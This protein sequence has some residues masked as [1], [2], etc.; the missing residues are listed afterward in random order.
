[1][2]DG[3]LD[4]TGNETIPA[5]SAD[6][7]RTFDQ[8]KQP[9]MPEPLPPLRSRL[10]EEPPWDPQSPIAMVVAGVRFIVYGSLG[11]FLLLIGLE[12]LECALLI[13]THS[14]HCFPGDSGISAEHDVI[15]KGLPH[16]LGGS[17]L[18]V[19]GA[20]L[21]LT[22]IRRR[23]QHWAYLWIGLF[24]ILSGGVVGI[25]TYPVLPITVLCASFMVLMGASSVLFGLGLTR[26]VWGR[27]RT[28]VWQRMGGVVSV[29]VT[30][31]ALYSFAW[32][33]RQ[34]QIYAR[35]LA[36]P[37]G[38][39]SSCLRRTSSAYDVRDALGSYLYDTT[40]NSFTA[41]KVDI[42]T[43]R[44]ILIH[45]YHMEYLRGPDPEFSLVHYRPIDS[46]G[47]GS[48]EDF[49]LRLRYVADAPQGGY[50]DVTSAYTR[51]STVC[52][53]YGISPLSDRIS[54]YVAIVLVGADQV[55]CQSSDLGFPHPAL[56]P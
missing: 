20:S 19:P 21:C 23:R 45:D 17:L 12:G 48:Y 26:S 2:R 49:I 38:G 1:M 24:L 55:Q 3:S 30:L 56:I 10:Q 5:I 47:D 52:P 6:H 32:L 39:W 31:Y 4:E 44:D 13:D 36:P 11:L 28:P 9:L 46:D 34:Y 16:L 43:L 42:Q 7:P 50:I 33:D 41:L 37:C 51:K 54:R 27:I 8:R 18:I 40:T 35:Q 29:G 14:R 22:A 53:P 15:T 25:H